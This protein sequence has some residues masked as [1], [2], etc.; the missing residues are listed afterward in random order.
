[1]LPAF[2]LDGGRILR[3]A[4][5]HFTEDFQRATRIAAA[6]GSVLAVV[7]I[8]LGVLNIIAGAFVQGIWQMLIGF[9]VY[10]AAGASR[11]HAEL[12]GTLHGVPVSR[13]MRRE[14]VSVPADTPVHAL[15]D[16]YFYR[17]CSLRLLTWSY[18]LDC[19]RQSPILD[20]TEE[21]EG[22]VLHLPIA[23]VRPERIV[24][25]S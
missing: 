1:M 15:I 23:E 7:L 9:F 2:P 13:I 17:Q 6:T 22:R 12:R 24:T 20:H 21:G 11:A 18:V 5:W 14:V 4:V 10:S 16:K 19:L 3:A 25:S 8:G